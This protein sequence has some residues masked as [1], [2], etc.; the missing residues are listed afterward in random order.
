MPVRVGQSMFLSKFTEK[1][2][3]FFRIR[4]RVHE[5]F[6]LFARSFGA[7]VKMTINL[8]VQS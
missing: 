7:G 5:I 1:S 2:I 6:E 3:I 4:E 8:L